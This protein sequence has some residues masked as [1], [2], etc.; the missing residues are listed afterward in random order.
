VL[1]GQ[2]PDVTY[3]KKFSGAQAPNEVV[4]LVNRLM[5]RLLAGEHPALVALREQLNSATIS[6]VEM[7][8][9][10]FYAR[11]AVAAD[12]PLASPPRLT[13]GSAK[14]ELSDA[15]HGAGCVL[16]VRDGRLSTLEGYTYDDDWPEDA[17]VLSVG[18]IVP[19]RIDEVV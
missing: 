18:D 6:E 3:P 4:S 2:H 19:I 10:G 13:G 9:C 11:F 8:G 17:R 5:P 15:K 12:A 14:I 1:D 7:T 16:F